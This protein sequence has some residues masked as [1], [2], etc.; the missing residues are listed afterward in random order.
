[1]I[2]SVITGINGYIGIQLQKLL[3]KR[4]NKVF[5]ID[6]KSNNCIGEECFYVNDILDTDGLNKI[7]KK[8]KP[9]VIYHLAGIIKSDNPLNLYEANV[10]GTLSLFEAIVSLGLK[11]KV[12]IP[13]SSAVYGKDEKNRKL[14][15]LSPLV[16]CTSYGTSKLLQE[17]VAQYYSRT[18]SIPV[19]IARTFNIIGPG[20]SINL[21]CSEFAR[22][23]ALA[24]KSGKKELHTGTLSNRRDFIDI[25]DAVNAYYLIVNR[26]KAGNIYN[27][28]S[29]KCMAVKECLDILIKHAD[30]KMNI[31]TDKIKIQKNDLPIQVGSPEKI[32]RETG[33]ESEISVDESLKD[34]LEYWRNDIKGIGRRGI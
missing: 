24:E 11:P 13:G 25:R 15:E 28:C 23:I 31:I 16:P 20:N 8:V 10:K 26:G 30:F 32:Y 6:I 2:K 9:D 17:E 5:G 7:F 33:W 19:Y 18:Y 1:M 4:Q 12:F 29:G 27:V 34:C 14:V 22:Q 21:A 3:L